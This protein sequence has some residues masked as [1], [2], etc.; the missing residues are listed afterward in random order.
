MYSWSSW[1]QMY[2]FLHRKWGQLVV[3]P[4]GK[5]PRAWTAP[6]ESI[7]KTFVYQFIIT[8]WGIFSPVFPNGW[9]THAST[10]WPLSWVCLWWVVDPRKPSPHYWS[11]QCSSHVLKCPEAQKKQNRSKYDPK[12]KVSL[13]TR[14]VAGIDEYG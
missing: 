3:P 1:R 2:H 7:K 5:N 10:C 9:H 14:T 11:L 4:L 13:M 12:I 6:C 8:L